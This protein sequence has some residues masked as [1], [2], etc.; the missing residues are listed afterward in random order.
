MSKAVIE[1]VDVSKKYRIGAAQ[2]DTLRDY[3]LNSIGA[4]R[5]KDEEFL[6]LN[7][8]SAIIDQG[9]VFGIIGKNGAGK[10]TLLKLISRITYP[11]QGY[12][13]MTGRVASLLE[14]GTGFHPELTGREN[15]YLNGSLLGMNRAEIK[16]HFDAIVDFS[17]VAKFLDTPVKHY[18]SGMYVR[19]AFAVA[20]HLESDI[21][22][23][24]E[25][26]AVGDAEFQKKCLG[27]MRDV[28]KEG[29]TVV[30]VSHNLDAVR[31]L[32]TKALV[33]SKGEKVYQG[34]VADAIQQ[35]MND[36]APNSKALVW[37]PEKPLS[38]EFIK[39][40]AIEVI[41]DGAKSCIELG[42]AF[43]L[44]FNL[45]SYFT[46]GEP[47]DVTFSLSTTEGT[48]ILTSS[49]F[50]LDI[51]KTQLRNQRFKAT[52]HFPGHL[53]NEGS[54][55]ISKFIVFAKGGMVLLEMS[56]CFSFDVVFS[57]DTIYGLNGRKQ[58][59]L[60]PIFDWNYEVKS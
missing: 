25:V 42:D 24:D 7:N 11:T 28:S 9:D 37:S 3:L 50:Y 26:L 22:I 34:G 46:A 57:P 48:L 38:S 27:R 18:S 51:E 2:Q 1:I 47:I 40:Y 41:T 44:S 60:R 13:K 52:C 12:I 14:V 23:I 6:A 36:S 56:D 33:L 21:L 58:G 19:L 30:F 4:F 49:T 5:R 35:Y 43:S 15:I 55:V 17:G 8:I 39:L 10:S 31:A 53:L 29:R 45:E 54:Y 59:L 16:K 20:A 32:C